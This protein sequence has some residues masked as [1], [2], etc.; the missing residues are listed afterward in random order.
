VNQHLQVE[1]FDNV[2]AVGDCANLN[3]P[4]MAY[5]AGLHAAVAATNIKNSL[6][7]K[8]LTSYRT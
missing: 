5:H 1:G 4:K 8:C 7:G 2:Y 6:T 3:E